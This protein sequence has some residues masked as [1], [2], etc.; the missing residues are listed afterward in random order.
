MEHRRETISAFVAVVIVAL[1]RSWP[2]VA[3]T[4]PCMVDFAAWEGADQPLLHLSFTDTRLNAWIL[5]WVQ[6]AI[7]TAPL[8]M[9]DAN[10]FHPTRDILA[11]SE[12]LFG[13]AL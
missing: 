7:T 9:F 1:A 3:C 5:A 8:A 4:A 13:L 10:I 12:H 2:L 11:G 6:H